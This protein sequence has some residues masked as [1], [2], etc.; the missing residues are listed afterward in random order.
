[1]NK[2][3]L[4]KKYANKFVSEL[5][6]RLRGDV[7]ADMVIYPANGNGAVVEV[8]LLRGSSRK[9]KAIQF[10]ADSPTVNS[11]LKKIPQH[12]VGGNIDGVHFAGTNIS[13]ENNRILL[14]KGDDQ[15]WSESD[16]IADLSRVFNA[17]SGGKA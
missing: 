16:A 13:L 9:N 5:R 8:K 10:A 14:I 11:V 3:D 4:L 15:H 1:M 17:Q 7:Q 6:P 2:K 12:F